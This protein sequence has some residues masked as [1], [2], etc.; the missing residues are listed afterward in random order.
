MEK[1]YKANAV[2]CLFVGRHND[3][4]ILDK[5]YKFAMLD[6]LKPH[7]TDD[8]YNSITMYY[9]REQLSQ[10][11][12]L[13]LIDAYGLGAP[14]M[15]DALRFMTFKPQSPEKLYYSA[16]TAGSSVGDA[17][18]VESEF[19]STLTIDLIKLEEQL[20][21]KMKEAGLE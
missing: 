1:H 15:R 17:Q 11:A 20:V 8:A 9:T 10:L 19:A 18:V 21:G 2:A 4:T 16:S 13:F 12:L 6:V 3:F 7:H 14:V 5:M